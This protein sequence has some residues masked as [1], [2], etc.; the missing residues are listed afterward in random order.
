M[1][2]TDLLLSFKLSV[3]IKV[4]FYLRV[5]LERGKIYI[6]TLMYKF[7]IEG[8]RHQR[9]DRLFTNQLQNYYCPSMALSTFPIL[10][11]FKAIVSS[12]KCELRKI[13][14]TVCKCLRSNSVTWKRQ[15][16]F[17]AN[18]PYEWQQ[19]WLVFVFTQYLKYNMLTM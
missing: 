17:T 5:I 8:D 11:S 4:T 16:E 12:T 7:S 9:F 15:I 19:R 1:C 6:V 2:L 13:Q 10:L 18:K 14:F 3:L